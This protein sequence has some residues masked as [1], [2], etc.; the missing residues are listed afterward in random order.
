MFRRKSRSRGRRRG[1]VTRA[2][3]SKR[4]SYGGRRRG[5][6]RVRMVVVGQRM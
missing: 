1:Y 4:R 2:Y 3:R 6:R 5:G